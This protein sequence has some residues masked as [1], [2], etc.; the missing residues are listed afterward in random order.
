LSQ[1][2]SPRWVSR[3]RW[4]V[5]A[6]LLIRKPMLLSLE[7]E[8]CFAAH[9]S[10][11]ASGRTSSG[12]AADANSA[13]IAAIHDVPRHPLDLCVTKFLGQLR[14]IVNTNLN[15]GRQSSNTYFGNANLRHLKMVEN[16]RESDQRNRL[17]LT[18]VLL[19]RSRASCARPCPLFNFGRLWALPLISEWPVHSKQD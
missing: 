18:H 6:N 3:F 12:T 1:S 11:S 19:D 14:L 13:I 4:G 15:I 5:K 7:L 10:S 16:V 2:I 17:P 8:K 9:D